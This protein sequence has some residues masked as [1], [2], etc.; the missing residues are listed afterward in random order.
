MGMA[1]LGGFRLS[2]YQGGKEDENGVAL[3]TNGLGL[4][5]VRVGP[6]GTVSP[7][8]LLALFMSVPAPRSYGVVWRVG[9][10]TCV[11]GEGLLTD[12]CID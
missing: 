8:V 2:E 3:A 9:E 4:V 7:V 11:R 1:C 12:R 10:F 5:H 6:C